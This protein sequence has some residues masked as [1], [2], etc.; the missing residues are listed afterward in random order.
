MRVSVIIPAYNEERL[1]GESLRHIQTAMTAFTRRGWQTELIVCNNNST[2]RTAE[3]AQAAGA[4]VVFEPINQIGRARNRGAEAATGDWLIFVDA[5]THPSA[6]L[7]DDVAAQIDTG[8]CLAGGSTIRLEAGYPAGTAL[9][10][11]WNIVSR[12]FRWVA[13]S[14]IFCDAAAFR[15]LGGFDTNLFASE[16][17][18]L[19]KRLKK[20]ARTERKRIVIVHRHPI[21][22]SAR[23]LRLYSAREH[24]LFMTKTI[25]GFGKTLK[26]R[27]ACHPWYDG[28][29]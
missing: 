28:R 11:A 17:I 4:T 16:E 13:G 9:T 2:D 14:F 27:E 24:F 10:H 5:D 6:E 29:R 22:T 15:K 21:H 8:R 20:L 3:V 12:T 19:S 23:K 18:E 1:L 26:S 7:F 25:L